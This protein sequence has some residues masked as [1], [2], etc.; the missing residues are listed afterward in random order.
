MVHLSKVSALRRCKQQQKM[1]CPAFFTAHGL[2][3]A[4]RKPCYSGWMARGCNLKLVHKAHEF[5]YI[6][7]LKYIV[8]FPTITIDPVMKHSSAPVWFDAFHGIKHGSMV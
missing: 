1:Q 6:H 7:I 5:S 8:L 2:I 4:K 3:C